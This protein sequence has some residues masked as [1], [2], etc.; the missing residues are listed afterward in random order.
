MKMTCNKFSNKEFSNYMAS[1]QAKVP[2]NN[3]IILINKFKTAVDPLLLEKLGD[4][5]VISGYRL[6]LYNNE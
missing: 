4:S 5:I 6:I 1:L 2:N 3:W